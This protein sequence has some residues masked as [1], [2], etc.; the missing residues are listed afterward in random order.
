M[1][2]QD[3][4][5]LA[6]QR[7]RTARA[8]TGR[9]LELGI[10]T[11]R[12]LPH[13]SSVEEVVGIE[14]DRHMLRQAHPR[15]A[16]APFPVRL[17]E[18]SAEALPFGEHEFDTIVVAL[19]LCT[20]PDPDAALAEARRVLKPDG[21]ILFLEHV[22]SS[23]PRLARFQDLITPVWMVLAGGCHP[24]RATVETIERH[25]ELEHL[26]GKGVIVQGSARAPTAHVA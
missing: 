2:P 6:R 21:R 13:Y 16:A 20:I 15:A 5:G 25:F 24:N 4:L 10:G 17:V 3:R 9:V 19:A 23:R 1:E 11:G 22:R 7:R 8:A 14:P 18:G 12:N 26:W